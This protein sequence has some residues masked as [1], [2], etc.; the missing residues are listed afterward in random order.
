MLPV[1]TDLNRIAEGKV[2]SWMQTRPSVFK[3]VKSVQQKEKRTLKEN[4]QAAG[5]A[6]Y[7]ATA[8]HCSFPPSVF[9]SFSLFGAGS[10][11]C[12]DSA[13]LEWST[14]TVIPDRR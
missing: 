10:A 7:E 3:Y 11:A 1:C 9:V 12:R 4:P 13:G 8:L 14:A 5:N 2:L 6:F